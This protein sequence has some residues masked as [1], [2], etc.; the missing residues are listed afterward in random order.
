M[1]A[2]W[3][4]SYFDARREDP[5]IFWVCFWTGDDVGEAARHDPQRITGAESV[6]EVLDWVSEVREGR[7]FELFVETEDRAET[8]AH[9]RADYRKLIRLAGDFTPKGS[10]FTV[11]LHA[12]D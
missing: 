5:S 10:T 2:E 11:A 8:S 9:G 6:A 3:D 4:E 7:R 12:E 1:H